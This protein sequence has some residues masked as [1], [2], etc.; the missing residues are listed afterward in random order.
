MKFEPKKK[1]RKKN[2]PMKSLLG[3]M[4][5]C[6]VKA[7]DRVYY[8][9]PVFLLSYISTKEYLIFTNVEIKIHNHQYDLIEI[10]QY[11]FPLNKYSI[12]VL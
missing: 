5:I 7:E 9:F 6:L 11:I 3:H 2:M 1:E 8:A 4:H 12:R 10:I